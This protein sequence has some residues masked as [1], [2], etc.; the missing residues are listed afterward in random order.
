M[1]TFN[2]LSLPRRIVR[3]LAGLLLAAGC[4]PALAQSMGAIGSM[5]SFWGDFQQAREQGR[6]STIIDIDNDSLLLNRNDGFYSSGVRL[7]RQFAQPAA[8]AISTI[9]G[10]RIGQ[11]L[12]TAS[13]IKLPPQLVG[14]PDHPHAGWLY[15]GLFRETRNADGSYRRFGLDLGCLGPCAGGR[16]T[17]TTLHRI[18]DQPKPQGWSRQVRNEAGAVLYAD[19]APLRWQFGRQV[20]LTPSVRGRFG[21]IHTDV[22]ALLLLRGGQLEPVPDGS[23]FQTY[24]RVRARV[25]GYDATLQGGY[26]SNDNPHVVSPKRLVAEVELGLRWMVGRYTL[27]AAVVRIGN[28]IADLPNSIGNQNVGRL[29]LAITH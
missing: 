18:I 5:G 27:S 1:S 13:D 23:A 22:A 25:V 8:G 3:T 15:A 28:E 7:T 9:Y 26:F 12:Y 6:A 21:N 14:P 16:V 19:I 11:E 29:Q 4:A 20:D 24:A 17:Q 10:W 2:R